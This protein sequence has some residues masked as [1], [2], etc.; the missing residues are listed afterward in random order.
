MRAAGLDDPLQSLDGSSIQHPITYT[1]SDTIGSGSL[2]FSITPRWSLSLEATTRTTL[3][4]TSGYAGP[5]AWEDFGGPTAFLWTDYYVQTWALVASYQASGLHLGVGPSLNRVTLDIDGAAF[6]EQR[7]TP[8]GLVFDAG[9][10]LPS[11]S[12]VF[13]DLDAQYRFVLKVSTRPIGASVYERPPLTIP[14]TSLSLSHTA[15]TVGLGF[16]F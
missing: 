7:H 6:Q 12:Q 16:R 10:R 13:L 14:G 9:V 11:R 3:G 4:S 1:S 2:A 5:Y 15:L 8:F